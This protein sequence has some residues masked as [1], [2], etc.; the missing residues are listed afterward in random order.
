M[1]THVVRCPAQLNTL[2]D[3]KTIFLAG[4][5]TGCP[6]WQTQFINHFN[7]TATRNTILIDPRRKDFD[8]KNDEM[9]SEQIEWEHRHILLADLKIF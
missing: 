1:A 9:E 6:E 4:G 5:I 2:E 3:G 7:S 8:V